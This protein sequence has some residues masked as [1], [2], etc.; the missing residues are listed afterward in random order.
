M[1]SVRSL[2]LAVGPLVLISGSYALTYTHSDAEQRQHLARLASLEEVRQ[3]QRQA[4]AQELAAECERLAERVPAMVGLPQIGLLSRPPFLL[5]STLS[6]SEM[7]RVHRDVLRPLSEAL[8]RSYFDRRPT[9]PLLIILLQDEVTF[10]QV[11]RTLDGYDPASYD[12]YYQ[13][14]KQ[15]LVLNLSRGEGTLAHELCH[16]LAQVD[17]PQ[18]PEWFDEGLAALH[19]AT[20]FSQDGLLLFGRPNWRCQLLVESLD[21][22]DFPQLEQIARAKSFRGRQEGVRYA[23]VRAFCRYLQ[24]KGML[25]HFYRKFRDQPQLDPSGLKTLC[26]LLA[27]PSAKAID[28]DFHRWLLTDGLPEKSTADART[29][30]SQTVRAQRR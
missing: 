14:Q 19:E 23:Y 1:L 24:D 7:E 25:S 18:L 11:A 26:E 13:R 16:A 20:V 28:A 12:G 8:W 3:E 10:R 9:S 2:L 15:H 4:S 30:V 21:Q 22:A 6:A 27:Q 17:F 5:A 29:P